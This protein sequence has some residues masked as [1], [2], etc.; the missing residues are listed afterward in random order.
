LGDYFKELQRNYKRYPGIVPV[1]SAIHNVEKEMVIYRVDPAKMPDLPKWTKGISSFNKDHHKL[2]GTSSDHI[3]EER[4]PC[5][6]LGQLLDD[7]QVKTID[8]LQ[9]DTEGYDEIMLNIDFN[10]IKPKSSV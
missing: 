8:L 9:I 1:R 4:V 7:Y 10:H 6:S 5:I 3:I 2:S